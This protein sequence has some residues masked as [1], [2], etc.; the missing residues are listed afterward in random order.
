MGCGSPPMAAQAR[1]RR[2]QME[3]NAMR[4]MGP[5]RIMGAYACT[6]GAS[7]L[8]AHGAICGGICEE[9]CHTHT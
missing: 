2:P 4:N 1:A 8:V 9:F 3:T 7:A 5:P 6:K